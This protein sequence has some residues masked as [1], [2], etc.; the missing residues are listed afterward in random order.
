VTN[1]ES[2]Q[3]GKWA[4]A[5]PEEEEEH[6]RLFQPAKLGSPTTKLALRG[7]WKSNCTIFSGWRDQ[8]H[9]RNFGRSRTVRGADCS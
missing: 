7:S 3:G 8:T 2:V 9:Y 4:P 6:D 5:L 1:Q